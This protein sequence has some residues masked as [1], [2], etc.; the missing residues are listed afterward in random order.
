MRENDNVIFASNRN[1]SSENQPPT[2][3]TNDENATSEKNLQA[4][5]EI[6]SAGNSPRKTSGPITKEP[7]NGKM[8]R[9]STRRSIIAPE[10]PM[11]TTT[12]GCLDTIEDQSFVED[13]DPTVERGRFFVKVVGAKD[14]NIPLPRSEQLR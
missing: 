4:P 8:R 13:A 7:W 14:L 6:K 2:L 12:R 1:V 10:K 9:H 5:R 11:Q 3:A